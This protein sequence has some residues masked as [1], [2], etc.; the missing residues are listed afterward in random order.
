MAKPE[1]QPALDLLTDAPT[2]EQVAAATERDRVREEYRARLAEKLKDPDFRKIEG[3]PIGTDEAILALSDPPYYTAC[4]NPFIE[5][6]LHQNAKPYAAET[7]TYHRE[8][9]AADVSEGKNDPIYNAHSYHTKV[10]HK[11]IMRYILHYTEPGDVVYDGFC[12]TGMTGVAA[13]LCNDKY[14]VESLGYTVLPNG[15]ILDA[16]GRE[17]SEIGARR[18]ILTDLSP[19]A[20]FI[21]YNYNTP[22]NSQIFAREANRILDEVENECSWLYSTLHNATDEELNRV[23]EAISR[24]SSSI[25]LREFYADLAISTSHIRDRNSKLQLG[26]INYT[27]WSD[28]LT[29]PSCGAEIVFWDASVDESAGTLRSTFQCENCRKE[30]KKSDCSRASSAFYDTTIGNMVVQTKQVPCDLSY[31]VLGR[32]YKRKANIADIALYNKIN[33]FPIPYWYPNQPMML[34]GERWGDTYRAGVHFGITHVH[35]F[36]TRRNMY[37][38]AALW[39]RLTTSEFP[40]IGQRLKFAFTAMQRAVSRLAGVATSYYFHGGG[41]AINAGSKGTMYISGYIPE[42]NVIQSFESRIGS[43]SFSV[44]SDFVPRI[45]LNSATMSSATSSSVDYIFSDPPFGNVQMYSELNFL[46][47][48]WLGL[49][50]NNRLEAITSDSQKKSLFDYQVLMTRCFEDHYRLLKSGHWMTIKFHNSEN[51]VWNSIQESLAHVG[52]VVA[53][54][55]VMDKRHDTIMQATTSAVV[56]QDLIIACYKPRADFESRFQEIK[57]KPEGVLEFVRQHLAM[58]PVV[59]VTSDGK[60]E[61]VA[62]RTRFLLFDRMI[63][64]H[65]QHGASIPLDSS[66]FYKLL[67]D[68][69]TSREDMYFLP[70]QAASYD[71]LRARGVETEQFSIFVQDEKTCVQWI[72]TELIKCPRS[73]GDLTPMFMQELRE[74]PTHEPRPE[75]RDMLREYFIQDTSG[76]WRVPNPDDERDIA[77][78][79]KNSLIRLFQNYAREKGVLKTFRKEAVVEGFKEC[80]E[81]KQ[82]SVIVSVCER[83]PDKVFQEIPE[84]VMFYDIAKDLAPAQIEQTEF[85]WE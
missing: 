32:K 49:L 51:A 14:H 59:P 75:L 54:V 23:A 85:V 50:T 64:Y 22:V 38:L 78:L 3:F 72:R 28:V 6:W 67:E 52:F 62:E 56:K 57:G 8:P 31:S 39:S 7:D 10:P 68:Q 69:F 46:W 60:L 9:F 37:V 81:T 66:A 1:D 16:A 40:R 35:H 58:L 29:C 45:D 19:A 82:F 48:A 13:Q 36:Y 61:V 71:A 80:Y 27:I 70:E 18:A 74:W 43:V 63:G 17:F 65:L 76:N 77:A 5:E 84:F 4:P 15:T 53:D 44:E 42:V 47:E 33:S 73:L 12:G 21:A 24:C 11:A 79:R 2:P 26:T 34:K 55:R 20:T 30:L 25:E 41:G 83:I